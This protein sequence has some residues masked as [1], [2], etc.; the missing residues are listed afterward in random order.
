[1]NKTYKVTVVQYYD[2]YVEAPDYETADHIAR[3]DVTWDEHLS[4]AVIRLEKS[5]CKSIE[6]AATWE[7]KL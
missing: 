1:M 7:G 6:P 2:F 4:E 3:E 5:D